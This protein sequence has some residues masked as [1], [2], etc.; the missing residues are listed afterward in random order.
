MNNSNE[1]RR[2]EA[3]AANEQMPYN[4]AVKSAY[5]DVLKDRMNREQEISLRAIKKGYTPMAVKLTTMIWIKRM[6]PR[7]KCSKKS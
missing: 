1:H 6:I 3:G 2:E 5:A 4:K 7:T